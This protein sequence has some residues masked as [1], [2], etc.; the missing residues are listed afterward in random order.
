MKHR[1]RT[2]SGG[3]VANS[4][5]HVIGL[6]LGAT[7][8]R[9]A[10]LCPERTKKGITGVSAHRL[11]SVPL[12]QGA[13]VGGVVEDGGAVTAALRQ[14]WKER[15][16]RGRKVVL[17]VTSPQVAVRDITLPDVSA[18]Q[19][20]KTLPFQ[21][22]EVIALPLDRALLDFSPL[23]PP[24]EATGMVTG[25]LTGIPKEPVVA[26]VHAV[27]RAKLRVARVDLAPFGLLRAIG[28]SGPAIE[29]LV[30]IGAQLT[31]IVVHSNGIANVVRVV[32]HGADEW[33]AYLADQAGIDRGEAEHVKRSIGATGT[34]SAARI[35]REAVRPV[36]T[37]VRGSI[38]FF[39]SQSRVTA[40]RIVLTGAGAQMPGLAGHIAEQLAAPTSLAAALRHVSAHGDGAPEHPE[41]ASAVAVGL[42]MGLAA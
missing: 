35:L 38:N 34:S 19:R 27:E 21:A 37:E 36:V 25:L 6:D 8:V 3:S 32:P 29:A 14:L 17:G 11:G 5:G 4:D 23:G 13:V 2:A 40:E 33:T 12:P 20:R 15:R 24:D 28:T 9:A 31:T 1:T 10:V 41:T 16:I 30:D 39:A 18:D 7:A 26:A 22:R 42:A